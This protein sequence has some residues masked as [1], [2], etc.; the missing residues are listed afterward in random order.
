MPLHPGQLPA[1]GAEGGIAAEVG[2]QV[3]ELWLA[4]GQGHRHQLVAAPGLHY[5][6]PALALAVDQPIGEGAIGGAGETAGLAGG[7]PS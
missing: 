5:A 4:P 1:I 3:Q 2:C 7:G 6:Q